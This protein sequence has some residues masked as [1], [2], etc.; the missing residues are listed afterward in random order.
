[1]VE[2]PVLLITFANPEYTRKTFEAIKKAEPKILYFYSN[3]AR[4][5]N[6]DELFRNNTVRELIEEIDW[7]CEV[8]TFFRDE[9]VDVYTSL[10]GAI[11][12]IFENEEQAII[13]EDDCVP[14]Q[15]YFDFCDQLLP[16]FKDDLRVWVISGNNFIEGYNPNGYDYIFSRFPFMYGWATWKSRWDK[17]LREGIPFDEMKDYR[18]YKQLFV[19]DYAA[20]QREYL[21]EATRYSN[22]WDYVLHSTMNCNGG[23]GIVPVINL[24][25]NIG[26]TGVHQKKASKFVHNRE[27][28]SRNYYRI[29][30]APPFIVPDFKYDQRFSKALFKRRLFVKKMI[31]WVKNIIN[32]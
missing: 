15:A 26:V 20:K 2:S 12:W 21:A 22:A 3:K 28:S 18:L 29:E 32:K 14:S 16:K 11:D 23:M 10:W 19:S 13:F 25:S 30:S 24:V 31:K 4:E 7:D 8:K 9:Y 1:M 17:V 5:D 6:S 27:V